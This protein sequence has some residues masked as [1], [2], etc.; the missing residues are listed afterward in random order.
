MIPFVNEL[1]TR[2]LG[3]LGNAVIAK[4]SKWLEERTGLDLSNPQLSNEQWVVLRN[5]EMEHE[6]ELLRIGLE[7][8]RLELE[9]VS[10]DYK[11]AADA[12]NMQVSALS[13][14]DVFSKRFVYY[15]AMVWS[16]F[17]MIFIPS[18]VFYE[19]PTENIRF[20]DTILGVVLGT[21]LPTIIYFFFGSSRSSQSKDSAIQQLAKEITK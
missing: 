14:E 1:L 18:I 8:S 13:Q 2:G 12:R 16:L 21:I 6:E 20:A 10:L 11:D 7:K 17:A 15:F 4:G 5:F 9:R 3:I 19:I